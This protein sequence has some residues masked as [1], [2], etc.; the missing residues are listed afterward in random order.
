MGGEQVYI[1]VNEQ[2]EEIIK[3]ELI[4]DRNSN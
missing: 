1:I 2:P 3:T 4:A